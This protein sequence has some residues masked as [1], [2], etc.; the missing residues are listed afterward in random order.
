MIYVALTQEVARAFDMQLE[1][2]SDVNGVDSEETATAADESVDSYKLW[3]P[4]RT[5]FL[6]ET[7]AT[8]SK[9]L[10]SEVKKHVWEEISKR[11]NEILGITITYKQVESKWKSLKR[12]YKSVL[13][14]NNTSGK[15]QKVLGEF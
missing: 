15:K 2:D 11:C 6:I 12:T 14:H 4:E 3:T 10:E 7:I 13:L 5:I 9:R 8:F 1:D